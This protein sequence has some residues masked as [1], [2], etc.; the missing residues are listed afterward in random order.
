[1]SDSPSTTAD[2]F[3]NHRPRLFALAYRLLGSRND[4]EDVVQEAWLRW[5]RAD[6]SVIRDLQAWLVTTTTRLGIDRLRLARNER[7]AYPG[8]WLP[9]PL[10]VDEA[11]PEHQADLASRISL[12]FLTLLEKL[13][14]EQ[15]SALL[16]KEAFDYDYAQIAE[17]LGTSDSNCRQM[18]HRARARLQQ[19]KPRFDVDA[20]QHRALLERFMQAVQAGDRASLTALLATNAQL[21]SDGGGKVTAVLRPLHGADRI[22]RLYWAV[23]RRSGTDVSFRLGQV[24]GEL[25]LLRLHGGQLH[26]LSTIGIDGHGRICQVLSVLNPD[27]LAAANRLRASS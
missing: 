18:V 24:N 3:E 21:L 16:L 22:A 19:D 17:I 10:T 11:G 27:K 12:A 5:H 26:S 15:R 13:P 8:P 2:T 4:A 9:E 6:Q 20:R 1:M 7:E 23:A 14:A 25:A